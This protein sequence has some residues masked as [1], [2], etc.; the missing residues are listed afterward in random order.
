MKK[1]VFL[2]GIQDCFSPWGIHLWKWRLV[3]IKH[4]KSHTLTHMQRHRELDSLVIYE[5]VF[6]DGFYNRLERYL[7]GQS[8]AVLDHRLSVGTVPTVHCKETRKYSLMWEIFMFFSCETPVCVSSFCSLHEQ[9]RKQH[10]IWFLYCYLILRLHYFACSDHKCMSEIVPNFLRFFICGSKESKRPIRIDHF[11]TYWLVTAR[12]PL[13]LLIAWIIALFYS[14]DSMKN[15]TPHRR[16][17][18]LNLMPS[19]VILFPPVPF[20][21]C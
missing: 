7:G 12:L 3:S 6:I 20:L 16:T 11:Q 2:F 21:L 19:F 15:E 14:G 18:K 17:L 5:G 8:V 13:V 9:Y 1:K 4:T 10:G